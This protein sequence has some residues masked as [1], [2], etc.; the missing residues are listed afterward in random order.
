[1]ALE[2]SA[3]TRITT[4]KVVRAE[5]W[6]VRDGE[7]EL[8]GSNVLHMSKVVCVTVSISLQEKGLYML[9]RDEGAVGQDVCDGHVDSLFRKLFV[10]RIVCCNC[11]WTVEK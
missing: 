8:V 3:T 1:M 9:T 2:Y 10:D 5:A 4:D 7:S 6:G 11:R